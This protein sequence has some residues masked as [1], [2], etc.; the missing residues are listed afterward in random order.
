M[1]NNIIIAINSEYGS[2]GRII[3]KN[4]AEKLNIKFY[5]TNLITELIK[6][7]ELNNEYFKEAETMSKSSIILS[8]SMFS[9]S[10]EIYGNSINE[11]LYNKQSQIIY[12]L[13]NKNSCV[14]VGRYVDFISNNDKIV[15]IFI[16]SLIEN[17]IERVTKI[18]KEAEFNNHT[19]SLIKKIDKQRAHH[20]F[21]LTDKEWGKSNNFDI[22]LN[23]DN[24]GIENC[25]DLI[26]NYIEN[27]KKE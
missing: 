11:K 13:I 14:V 18:Y 5:D 1:E 3:A 16:N 25:V 6:N 19:K 4:L 27:K 23:S 21:H 22:C 8:L 10:K 2:G 7:D 15:K 17:R 26:K 20:Y 9:P 24:I 12:N